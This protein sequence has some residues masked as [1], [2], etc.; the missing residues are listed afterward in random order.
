MIAMVFCVSLALWA[1][2]LGNM[3][4]ADLLLLAAVGFM[5]LNLYGRRRFGCDD[6][7]S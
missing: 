5:E 3:A 4:L 2:F 6:E 1:V 7:T